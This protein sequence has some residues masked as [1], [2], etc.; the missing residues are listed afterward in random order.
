MKSES[1]LIAYKVIRSLTGGDGG[2]S[3]KYFYCW[4]VLAKIKEHTDDKQ[5]MKDSYNQVRRALNKLGYCS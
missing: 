1:K 4:Q 2:F 5:L 3:A